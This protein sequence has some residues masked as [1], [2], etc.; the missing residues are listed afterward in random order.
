MEKPEDVNAS[1]A[2]PC[3]TALAWQSNA[4]W[5]SIHG[6]HDNLTTDTHHSEAHA[7]SVCD[8]LDRDGLGGEGIHF[9][10]R[11]WVSKCQ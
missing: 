5:E 10:V 4:E 9:P 1:C 7:Q 6:F 11:T 2:S 3:S 8:G